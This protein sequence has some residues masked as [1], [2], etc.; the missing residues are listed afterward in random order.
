MGAGRELTFA[1]P[2][3]WC[4]DMDCPGAPYDDEEAARPWRMVSG[5]VVQVPFRVEEC[6]ICADDAA[7]EFDAQEE[8]EEEE[9]WGSE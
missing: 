7:E 6:P 4:G 1:R 3:H 8:E 2:Q 9:W 5:V